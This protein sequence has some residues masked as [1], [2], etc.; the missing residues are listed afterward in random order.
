[1]SYE[2]CIRGSAREHQAGSIEKKVIVKFMKICQ[3][4]ENVILT[5]KGNQMCKE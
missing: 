3:I 5:I 1:M 4:M 2:S